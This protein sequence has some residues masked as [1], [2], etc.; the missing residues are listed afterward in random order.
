MG[1]LSQEFPW[2]E[3]SRL[4]RGNT[5]LWAQQGQ[6]GL[7]L[8]PYGLQP[9]RL[10][11]P[12][13]SPGKNTEVSCHALLQGV[14]LTQGSNLCLLCLLHCR[15]ILY[16]LS[17]VGKPCGNTSL[18]LFQASSW[19][20]EKYIIQG[21][22]WLSFNTVLLIHFFPNTPNY[23]KPI[24]GICFNEQDTVFHQ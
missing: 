4:L 21:L 24:I 18:T 3:G 8:Q 11:Y 16:P 15:Q 1:L 5:V 23:P 7:T 14:F 10:L 17:H 12:Q 13:D 9:T 6:L 2:H 19:N 22:A 20:Q